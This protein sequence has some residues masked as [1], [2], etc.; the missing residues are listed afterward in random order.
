MAC[1]PPNSSDDSNSSSSSNEL[2][3]TAVIQGD[4]ETLKKELAKAKEQAACLIIIRGHPQG[5]RYFLTQPEMTIGR[6]PATEIAP[7]DQSISRRHAKITQQN[8]VITLT[9]L[10]SSNGTF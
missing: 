1:V 7:S 6:D 10:S 3:K 5:H 9:D 4:A 2:E 8:G